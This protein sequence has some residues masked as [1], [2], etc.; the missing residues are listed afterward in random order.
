MTIT[1]EWRCMAHGD[2]EGAEPICPEGC[3]TVE[4]IFLTPP[5]FKSEATARIDQTVRSAAKSFGLTNMN[6]HDGKAAVTQDP[7]AAARQ[8]N[9]EKMV[10]ERFGDGWLPVPDGGT[11]N[12]GSGQVESVEGRNGP[13]VHGAGD[14][15]WRAENVLANEDVQKALVPKAVMAKAD[16]QKLTLADAKPI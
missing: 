10:H 6:N 8:R 2:F 15:P 16:P 9:Y 7:M 3:D 1:K 12:V 14:F 13:G 11:Y 4:R 5:G